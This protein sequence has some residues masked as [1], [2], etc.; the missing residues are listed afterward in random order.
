MG[1]SVT[2]QEREASAPLPAPTR[3]GQGHPSF[4]PSP[5]GSRYAL[6][7]KGSFDSGA[8]TLADFN[9]DMAGFLT[10]Y[11]R[12]RGTAPPS[13]G[14]T[15]PLNRDSINSFED[16][17]GL[18]QGFRQTMRDRQGGHGLDGRD[19]M[20]NDSY[21]TRRYEFLAES[22]GVRYRAY[23]DATG[24]PLDA[25]NPGAKEG[26]STIGIGFNMDRPEA[27]AIYR[28]ATGRNNFD[29]VRSGRAKITEEDAKRLFEITIQDAEDFV[30]NRFQGVQLTEHQRLALVSLAFNNPAL[31]GPNL[32]SMVR[33]GR[34]N[35]AR[36]E[37][38]YRSNRA[39]NRGIATRRFREAMMFVGTSDAQEA[40]PAYPEYIRQNG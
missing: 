32:T 40:L 21:T 8:K 30:R 2:A 38:L 14:I 12:D 1:V 27:R 4:S 23:D 20:I 36:D 9:R 28:R 18:T 34:W 16:V 37:I 33:E 31:I 39:Q 5:L 29:A 10:Q 15:S 17:L 25:D 26:L 35:E 22:E 3:P 6:P 11:R 19:T 24:Q 13:A 7:G